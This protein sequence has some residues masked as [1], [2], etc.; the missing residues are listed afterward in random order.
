M[1]LTWFDTVIAEPLRAG[2]LPVPRPRARLG[3]AVAVALGLTI[4]G[5]VAMAAH[6]SRASHGADVAFALQ[7]GQPPNYIFPIVIP[8]DALLANYGYFQDQMFRPLYWIGSGDRVVVNSRLSLANPPTFSNRGR[9]A[10]IVLKHTMW[11]DGVPVTSRD[12]TFWMNLVRVSKTN[13]DSYIPGHIPDNVVSVGAP[14]PSTVVITFKRAY[15]PQWLTFDQLNL[16]VPLP[17]QAWD[18]TAAGG[19]VGNFD[20]T[21]AGARAV[22]RFLTGQ[23][24][25]E[26]SYDTNSLWQVVD[27]PYRLK[28]GDGF[29]AATGETILV[30]NA[31]YSGITNHAI[32]QIT[33]VPFTSDA[34][35]YNALR[36]GTLTY[37]YVPLQDVDTIA[38]V[39]RL[40]YRIV[41]WTS[42]SADFI[43]PNFS[44]PVSGPLFRQLYVR[45]AI[46][47]LVDQPTYLRDIYKGYGHPTYGPVPVSP[48][49]LFAGASESRNLYPYSV[50]AAESLLRAHGWS[51]VGNGTDRCVHAGTGA[52]RCGPGVASGARMEFS[53]VYASG[54]LSLAQQM[55]AFKSALS[56]AGIQLSLTPSPY[57]TLFTVV[58]PCNPKTGLGC[59]WGMADWGYPSWTYTFGAYPSGDVLFATGALENLG[60]YSDRSADGLMNGVLVKPGYLPMR[61]YASYLAAQL[62]V[63]WEPLPPYQIS[64]IS[65]RLRGAIPQSPLILVNPETWSMAK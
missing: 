30:P 19:P 14:S 13:W 60:A 55:Q 44:N 5:P 20:R 39:R 18:R 26:P 27:G 28:R 62:P 34:A 3:L 25:E 7:P 2:V 33:L 22:Y 47:H 1:R 48:P 63:F 6:E 17:Q 53:M 21:A 31:H 52:G 36:S 59:R 54:D 16:I 50:A 23:A 9:T 35:E 57:N 61:E 43:T 10:T 38:S 49:N 58:L 37:G 64:A 32:S 40:G 15:N 45:Q 42:W 24:A 4:G 8:A 51:V 29:N 65:T 56:L 46:Q 11:S 41:P 12:I